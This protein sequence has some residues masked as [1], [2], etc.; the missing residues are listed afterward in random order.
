MRSTQRSNWFGLVI[1]SN[2]TL[3]LVWSDEVQ[4][5]IQQFF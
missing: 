5:T 1:Q 2:V 4:P 3:G